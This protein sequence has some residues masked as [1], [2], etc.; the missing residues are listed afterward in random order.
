M[1]LRVYEMTR[2]MI[3]TLIDRHMTAGLKEVNWNA[4]DKRG[5]TVTSGIYF[6]RL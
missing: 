5:K 1:K 4:R 2:K 6:Y 3:T